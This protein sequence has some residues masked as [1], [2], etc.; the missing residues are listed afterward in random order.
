MGNKILKIVQGHKYYH[1]VDEM[2]QTQILKM[3]SRVT[4]GRTST[5]AKK[6]QFLYVIG[7]LDEKKSGIIYLRNFGQ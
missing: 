7:C 2:W 3:T 1:L 4:R 6:M 5:D